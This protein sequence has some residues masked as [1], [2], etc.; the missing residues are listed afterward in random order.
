MRNKLKAF[1]VSI[2][3]VAF[4]ILIVGIAINVYMVLYSRPYIFSD[5]NDVPDRGVVIIP[6]AKV[7]QNNVSY[8]VHDRLD[9][10][11]QAIKN[12][13]ADVILISGDHGRKDYDE[14]NIMKKFTVK[15]YSIDENIIF[16]DHAGFS[17]YETM[18]RARDIFQVDRAVV[19]SQKF[20]T[21]RC[22]YIGRKLGMDIVA[23]EAP[24][25]Y[26]YRKKV[27]LSWFIREAGA[28][29]KSF[30]LVLTKADPTYYGD[31][32]PITGPAQKSWD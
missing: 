7:Y 9:G 15:N 20:H 24:E 21:A 17:T 3:S 28:R 12:G 18:I 6:G 27:R 22:V 5:I 11:V 13:K 26:G 8:V 32:I 29:I 4:F 25:L 14:V 31:V 19:V 2:V 30:F 1:F 23:Y 16:T 10:G